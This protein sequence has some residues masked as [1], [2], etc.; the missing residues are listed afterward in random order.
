[1]SPHAQ[2]QIKL[3]CFIADDIFDSLGNFLNGGNTG[4]IK[5]YRHDRVFFH[6]I[7]NPVFRSALSETT[8][9]GPAMDQ[10]YPWSRA[11]QLFI[12]LGQAGIFVLTYR[13]YRH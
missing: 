4:P 2:F 11:Y 10:L 13:R 3:T 9:T 8:L 5:S 6:H 7:F 1:M 12:T